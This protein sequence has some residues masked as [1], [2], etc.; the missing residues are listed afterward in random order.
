MYSKLEEKSMKSEQYPKVF[1]TGSYGY[2]ENNTEAAFIKYNRYF[3]PQ[4]GLTFGM[5][6][7]DGKKLRISLQNAKINIQNKELLLKE[8][9]EQVRAQI[10]EMYLDYVCQL[11]TISLGKK[12]FALAEKNLDI[13]TKAFRSGQLSSLDLRVAKDDLFQASSNLV[14][15]YYHAKAIETELLSVSCMLI[16]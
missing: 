3:G 16:K 4:V 15:A 7:F 12:E 2:Y 14:N 13:A 8:M 11:Q 1:L 9:Q 5:K 6:L 10:A